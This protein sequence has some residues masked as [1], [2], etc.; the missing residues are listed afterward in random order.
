MAGFSVQEKEQPA[1]VFPAP[2]DGQ[3]V[4]YIGSAADMASAMIFKD[5]KWLECQKK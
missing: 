4:A 2:S 3:V 1:A 5:G